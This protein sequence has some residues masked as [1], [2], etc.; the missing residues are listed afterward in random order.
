MAA[1]KKT[2]LVDLS[3][4]DTDNKLSVLHR[5]AMLHLNELHTYEFDLVAGVL[6]GLPMLISIGADKDKRTSLGFTAC[7]LYDTRI[8]DWMIHCKALY[9]EGCLSPDRFHVE[10][11]S[12]H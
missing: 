7:G 1:L 3:S 12:H 9:S 6:V 5:F 11:E 4:L 2:G 10:V 8:Q